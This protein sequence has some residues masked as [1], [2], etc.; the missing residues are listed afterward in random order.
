MLILRIPAFKM[1]KDRDN[2]LFKEL[3]T[4]VLLALNLE[5]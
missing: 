4:I 2:F 5:L 3:K 1:R